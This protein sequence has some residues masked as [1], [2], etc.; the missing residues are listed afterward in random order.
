MPTREQL[1]EQFGG[2]EN[3]PEYL[4]RGFEA[5]DAAQKRREQEQAD[6]EARKEAERERIKALRRPPTNVRLEGR[7]IRWEPPET[8]EELEP[9]GY[10]VSEERNGSWTRHGDYVLPH[11]RSATLF[12]SGPAY[13]ETVYD[14]MALGEMYRS[15]VVHAGRGS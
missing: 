11:I 5:Q 1:I 3:V 10:W 12:G 15:P 9:L 13:V 8:A 7:I 4:R 14:Q 6:Y 2:I